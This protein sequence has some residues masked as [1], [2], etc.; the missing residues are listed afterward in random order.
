MLYLCGQRGFFAGVRNPRG[1]FS[2]PFLTGEFCCPKSSDPPKDYAGKETYGIMK[3]KRGN[4]S[5]ELETMR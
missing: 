3:C 2:P 4:R 1:S 5:M